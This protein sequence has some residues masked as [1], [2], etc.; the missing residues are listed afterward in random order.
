MWLSALLC[1]E[2]KVL[3]F[4]HREWNGTWGP[5]NSGTHRN[6]LSEI[7]TVWNYS[8]HWGGFESP[9][10]AIFHYPG[11]L[12]CENN[13]ITFAVFC[14]DY[15]GKP[16]ESWPHNC[17]LQH[18]RFCGDIWHNLVLHVNSKWDLVLAQKCKCSTV[19]ANQQL[20]RCA[21]IYIYTYIYMY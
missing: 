16:F 8:F 10:V 11:F 4:Y 17:F 9:L 13:Y 3:L 5:S 20:V 15:G 14:I 7:K 12:D 18:N 6:A 19:T 1:S 21:H 2:N